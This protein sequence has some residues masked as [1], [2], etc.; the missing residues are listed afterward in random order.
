MVVFG[1]QSAEEMF[2]KQGLHFSLVLSLCLLYY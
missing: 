1:G 2:I